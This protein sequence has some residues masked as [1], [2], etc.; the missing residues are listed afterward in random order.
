MH[1]YV[2]GELS[3]GNLKRREELL[4]DLNAL[5]LA[6]LAT[7]SEVSRLIEDQRLW[8]RGLGWVDVHLLA[9][10]LITQTDFWQT[11]FWTFD[12]R[13]GRAARDLGVHTLIK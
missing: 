6:K 8:G 11:G 12:K 9:S 2:S 1:P 4:S 7:D 5:P 10:V 3:C 13:L